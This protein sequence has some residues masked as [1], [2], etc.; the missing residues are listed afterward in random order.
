MGS[1]ESLIKQ[2][3]DYKRKYYKNKAIKGAII[4]L[5]LSLA[6][7][8][9][10]NTIE[11]SAHLS[12]TGRGI[13]FYSFLASFIAASYGLVIQHLLLMTNSNKQMS[14]EEAA[15]QIGKYFPEVS[16]KLL[17]VIQLEK[18]THKQS[19][20]L[21]AGIQQKSLKLQKVPFL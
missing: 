12:K 17:N 2:L 7:F 19:D 6:A 8:V 9:L 18:L 13:L 4:L 5:S 15:V 11:F 14:N 10:I 21:I 16:D 20:L 3:K 1:N